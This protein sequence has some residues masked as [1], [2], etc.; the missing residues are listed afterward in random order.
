MSKSISDQNKK[1]FYG[2]ASRNSELYGGSRIDFQ[3]FVNQVEIS[4]N[5]FE[6]SDL[7][8]EYF[9]GNYAEANVPDTLRIQNAPPRPAFFDNPV[10]DNEQRAV[11][12]FM[13]R[14]DF[15]EKNNKRFKAVVSESFKILNKH[16]NEALRKEIS[17]FTCGRTAFAFLS[18]TYGPESYT[19][20]DQRA[21]IYRFFSTT[22]ANEEKFS[23]FFRRLLEASE[24]AGITLEHGVNLFKAYLFAQPEENRF[25]WAPLAPRLRGFAKQTARD[26][27][28][29]SLEEL[30]FRLENEDQRQHSLGLVKSSSNS[31][32]VKAVI[33]D[34]SST[35]SKGAKGSQ[36]FCNNCRNVGHVP[37]ECKTDAC[38]HCQKFCCGHKW[39]NCP[40]RLSS[41]QRP[42]S[43]NR[44][45]S[46]KE[47]SRE[48][49]DSSRKRQ[50]T[51]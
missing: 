39:H 32:N 23:S 17:K 46:A 36:A 29:E 25:G 44:R 33:K 15:V 26:H 43:S 49:N 21:A 16:C 45:E 19:D 13:K 24:A 18:R 35:S 7:L 4:I 48:S 8:R 5:Q 20:S 40:K 31:S 2:K 9:F 37:H 28:G 3:D 41:K 1:P 22:M 10:D 6:E 38:G 14:A 12:F 42:N 47:D 34:D 50:R 51:K 27:A 30:A 11:E